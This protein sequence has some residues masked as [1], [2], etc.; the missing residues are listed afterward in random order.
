MRKDSLL[1]IASLKSQLNMSNHIPII[2]HVDL[3]KKIANEEYWL[4]ACGKKYELVAHTQETIALAKENSPTLQN[5]PD[6][7][8]THYTKEVV[9][10]PDYK[11]MMI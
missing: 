1:P 5:Q 11:I 4:Y 3:S 2:Y 8:M 6:A 7:K 9:P 10:M